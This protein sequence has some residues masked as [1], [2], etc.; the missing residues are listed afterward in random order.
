MARKPIASIA[1]IV[2]VVF[3]LFTTRRYTQH[4]DAL[5]R[6]NPQSPESE[7]D[8]SGSEKSN[9]HEQIDHSQTDHSQMDHSGMDSTEME[10][11]HEEADME[12]MH[13]EMENSGDH[14][15]ENS[16]KTSE[17]MDKAHMKGDKDEKNVQNKASDSKSQSKTTSKVSDDIPDMEELSKGKP[18]MAKMPNQTI[19]AQVGNAGWK[20]LHTI[21]AQYPEEP[22]EEDQQTLG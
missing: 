8:G 14:K 16:D 22:S 13:E 1:L 6:Y 9:M 15:H 18:I 20:L 3:F 5:S 7:M 11:M 17:K 2:L 12:R 4:S 21:L 10:K 19:R